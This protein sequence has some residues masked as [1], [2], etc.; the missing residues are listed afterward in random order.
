MLTE[1]NLN[2]SNGAKVKAVILNE[3]QILWTLKEA[4]SKVIHYLKSNLIFELIILLKNFLHK[5]FK[6]IYLD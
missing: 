6:G 2:S 1:V 3:Q 5:N 4:L